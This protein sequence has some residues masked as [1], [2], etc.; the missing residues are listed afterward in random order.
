MPTGTS[1]MRGVVGLNED[2]RGPGVGRRRRPSPRASSR[3][4]RPHQAL[5]VAAAQRIRLRDRYHRRTGLARPGC[6]LDRHCRRHRPTTSHRVHLATD[7]WSGVVAVLAGTAGVLSQTAGRSNA[8]VGVFISVTTAPAAGDF[9]LSVALG[10]PG[11][12]TGSATQLG[13]NL[14]GMTLAGVAR[15]SRNEHCGNFSEHAK[16]H[17]GRE[18]Q[19]SSS[20]RSAPM[21]CLDGV[22]P[23]SRVSVR[24]RNP[25]QCSTL[26]HAGHVVVKSASGEL[27]VGGSS[28]R[29]DESAGVAGRPGAG[30]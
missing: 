29:V 12:L 11:Q 20:P 25:Y 18:T 8:L 24:F 23:P 2:D 4:P 30:G 19:K 13:V 14:A 27:H 21:S 6:R 1:P 9:A 22:S 26:T 10:A 28:S 17:S 3:T 5:G 15:W 7:K 16:L